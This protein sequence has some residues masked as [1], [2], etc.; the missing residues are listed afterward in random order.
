ML[1]RLLLLLCLF[2]LPLAVAQ[3]N[4][5]EPVRESEPYKI[6]AG[7]WLGIFVDGEPDLSLVLPVASNGTISMP[8]VN[9]FHAGGLTL[10]ELQNQI[11]Q[12][13][14][15]YVRDPHVQASLVGHFPA[16]IG[17]PLRKPKLIKPPP[18]AILPDS[19]P[20]G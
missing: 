9:D 17:V 1:L 5:Q 12:R 7:D 13:L 6:R 15:Q 16:R 14:E 19:W 11:R 4:G 3:E 20:S 10:E 2:P 8:L 18:P